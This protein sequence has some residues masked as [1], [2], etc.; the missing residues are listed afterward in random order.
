MISKEL[1]LVLPTKNHEGLV[2]DNLK[3]IDSYLKNNFTNY[4]IIVVSNGSSEH[5]VNLL[6]QNNNICINHLIFEQSG[7]GFAVR[8][9]IKKSSYRYILIC[10][11]DLSVDIKYVKKFFENGTPLANFVVGSRKLNDSSVKK[12]PLIRLLSG[13]IFTYL[14]KYYLGINISDTQC[15]FKLIDKS[16]F[17]N[18][19]KYNSNDF[20]Y[21]VELFLLAKKSFLSVTEVPVKYIHNN[22]SSISLLSDSVQMFF[23]IITIKKTMNKSN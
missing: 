2:L 1:T 14:T 21:D 11:A 3:Y 16:Q 23:K 20:F 5:N 17:F 6:K 15:G 12:T 19:N 4:E 7:K 18:C 13:G 9:G 10:D 8:E 22:K